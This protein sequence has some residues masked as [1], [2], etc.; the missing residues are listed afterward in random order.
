MKQSR[1]S[2]KG[3][4]VL[5]TDVHGRWQCR[6][7]SSK[8][9]SPAVLSKSVALI[10][11]PSG[12]MKRTEA[13]SRPARQQRCVSV[14]VGMARCV[15]G[16][17]VRCPGRTLLCTVCFEDL[18]RRER[19][20]RERKHERDRRRR[21]SSVQAVV[22]RARCEHTLRIFVLFLTYGREQVKKLKREGAIALPLVLARQLPRFAAHLEVDD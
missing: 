17:L 16:R 19:R 7:S 12:V 8:S 21:E 10:R 22:P 9:N 6:T 3:V 2:C 13:R 4:A 15:V 14:V 1:V 20:R 18:R 5:G 11:S